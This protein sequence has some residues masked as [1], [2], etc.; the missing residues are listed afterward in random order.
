VTPVAIRFATVPV[1]THPS[2][3]A[4]LSRRWLTREELSVCP[5]RAVEKRRAEFV[6][7]RIAAKISIA[8]LEGVGAGRDTARILV[9]R[10]QSAGRP[11]AI[12]N[13]A[14]RSRTEISITH[15]DGVAIAG[16]ATTRIGL[17]LVSVEDRAASFDVEAFAPGELAAWGRALGENHAP[18]AIRAIAFAAKEAA[19]KWRGTGLR[20]GLQSVRVA[21][22][23]VSDDIGPAD[24]PGLSHRLVALFSRRSAH[25]PSRW[26]E[27][28]LFGWVIR[29]ERRVLVV[30]ATACAPCS[31]WCRADGT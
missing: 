15:V 28:E 26:R 16:A 13:R 5:A 25:D 24:L 12:A 22:L 4:A 17:D 19:L 30:L 9:E 2:V 20:D 7:G 21:P 23:E 6:A 18:A 29:L 11:I 8:R 3:R 27:I 1:P 10:G 31:A 14:E